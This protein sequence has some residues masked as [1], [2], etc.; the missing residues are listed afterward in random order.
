MAL[1]G[2]EGLDAVHVMAHGAPGRVVFEADEWSLAT[3]E[4]DGRHL[5]AIGRALAEHGELRLWSC[6]TARGDTGAAFLKL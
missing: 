5:V 6:A 3:V 2:R 4:R 1:A